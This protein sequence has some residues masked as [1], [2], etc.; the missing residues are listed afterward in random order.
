[1]TDAEKVTELRTALMLVATCFR[2]RTQSSTCINDHHPYC[3]EYVTSVLARVDK[4][5]ETQCDKG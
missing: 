2:S 3:A 5:E 1:M 4:E